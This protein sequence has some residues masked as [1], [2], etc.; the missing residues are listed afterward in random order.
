MAKVAEL[1]KLF[2][3]FRITRIPREQNTEANELSRLITN[4]P[5][6]MGPPIIVDELTYP[7]ID[8]QAKLVAEIKESNEC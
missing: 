2:T 6:D 5:S 1:I 3:L 7:T 4:S 8:S